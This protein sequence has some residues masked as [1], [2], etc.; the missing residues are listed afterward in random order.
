MCAGYIHTE[1]VCD[2]CPYK[3]R[4]KTYMRMVCPYKAHT[5]GLPVQSL[6]LLQALARVQGT[7][8]QSP[9]K[10]HTQG[11]PI[12]SL[13]L[14]QALAR[15]QGTTIHSPYKAHKEVSPV[16]SLWLLQALAR[17][18]GTTIQSPNMYH[19]TIQSPNMCHTTI[20]SPK[21][22]HASGCPPVAFRSAKL[23]RVKGDRFWDRYTSVPVLFRPSTNFTGPL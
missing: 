2:L 15:V 5:Q 11:S 21:M 14:L 13:R 18:Q 10:A 7:T 4:P 3:G 8:I 19:A 23:I 20:Q 12:Q 16:Q 6:W 22:C 9:Y 1:F 17:V